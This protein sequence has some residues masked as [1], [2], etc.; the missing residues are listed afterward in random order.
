MTQESTLPQ[1]KRHLGAALGMR[2]FVEE[3][4][5][6]KVMG[7][8]QEVERL[9]SVA[10]AHPHAAYAAF[11][12]GLSSR[13]TYIA[14]TIPD[15]GDL[16]RPREEAIRHHFLPSLTGRSAFKR[17]WTRPHGPTNMSRRP[18][19]SQPHQTGSPPSQHISK[20]YHSL[21]AFILQQSNVYSP[22]S[23]D[24]QRQ[25]KLDAR[26]N[27]QQRQTQE[28]AE[29][30]ERLPN[31]MR[32]ALKVS[33]KKGASSW[34]ST[35]PI[36]E[37]CFAH[38]KGAFCDALCL[39]YGWHPPGLPTTCVCDISPWNMHWTVPVVAFLRWGTMSC[40]TSQCLTEVCHGVSTEPCL[41]PLS[42][43]PLHHSTANRED[44]AHLHIVAD[45]FWGGSRQRAFFD[46]RVFNPFVQSHSKSTLAHVTERMNRRRG[47]VQW[48]GQGSWTWI[49]SP[50]VFSTSGGMG[51]INTVVYQRLASMIAERREE[52]FSWTFFW[53]RCRLSFSLLHSAIACLRGTRSSQG[54][55]ALYDVINL[56][57]VE[58]R[59]PEF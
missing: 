12:H 52:P 47:G 3:F 40:E 13:W 5:Q 4:V 24:T 44:G 9:S 27:R 33:S 43:E 34:H 38:H 55:P 15:V 29:L 7:W 51:P 22:E 48:E 1:G 16:L 21:V 50:L 39:C 8:T 18:G 10:I 35:L 11:T 58:G 23:K 37:H 20:S 57:W 46:V 14:R 49:L 30:Q 19:H 36:A 31:D 6:Q 25:A 42:D 2:A 26:K 17:C 28:A 53:L 59:V 54:R 32:R 41:R 45:S 56:T